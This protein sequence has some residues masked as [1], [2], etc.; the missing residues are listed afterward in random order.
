MVRIQL[1]S[2]MHM[3]NHVHI[4]D[5]PIMIND[6]EFIVPAGIAMT[7]VD[8]FIYITQHKRNGLERFASSLTKI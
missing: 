7:P 1:D 6:T 4:A 3:Y 2:L 5:A 8:T